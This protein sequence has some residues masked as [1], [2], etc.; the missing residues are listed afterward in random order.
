MHY[1]CT[2]V[3][4]F[5]KNPKTRRPF[6][7]LEI[8][9]ISFNVPMKV[10]YKLNIVKTSL[11]LKVWCILISVFRFIRKNSSFWTK[12]GNSDYSAQCTLTD[13]DCLNSMQGCSFWQ[14]IHNGCAILRSWS[15]RPQHLVIQKP[16][17]Y[18]PICLILTMKKIFANNQ[19]F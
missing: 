17:Y 14:Y 3:G 5:K 11:R 8:S 6:F 1:P 7:S 13:K 4:I 16:N 12:Y 2:V 19:H 18:R 15:F 9:K 10:I